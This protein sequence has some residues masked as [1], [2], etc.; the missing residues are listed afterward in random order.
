MRHELPIN[1]PDDVHLGLEA[2]ETDAD[3][4]TPIASDDQVPVDRDDAHE[5]LLREQLMKHLNDFRHYA[6]RL[7]GN[8]DQTDDL[9]N[10]AIKHALD[11]RYQW[12]PDCSF[13][14]WFKKIL[15]SRWLDLQ[16]RMSRDPIAWG[17]EVNVD[18]E[19]PAA[20]ANGMF[21]SDVEK[22][23][24]LLNPHDRCLIE[25]CR[26]GF[27]YVEMAKELGIPKGTVMSRLNRAREKMKAFMRGGIEA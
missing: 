14:A 3:R 15:T 6:A 24:A 7:T 25:W 22:L 20:G 2:N 18:L 26:D 21:Q 13:K 11:R 8:R 17:T 27:T 16:K 10:E 4:T 5:A 9:L 23:L 19:D 12:R 1:Q